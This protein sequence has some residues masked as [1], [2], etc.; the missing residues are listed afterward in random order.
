M[1]VFITGASGF[2]GS[3]V[4]GAFARAGH[5]VCGLVRT[6]AK[7]RSLAT[8]EI[9]PI[10][11]SMDDPRTFA[12]R[13]GACEVLVHCA[14][15]YTE[16]FME[17]D[18]KTVEVLLGGAARTHRPRLFIYTSGVWVYGDTGDGRADESSET[19]PP[20]LVTARAETERMV[21]G[22]SQAALRTLVIRPGCVYGES[23]SLTAIWFDT[24]RKNGATRVVGEG[25]NRW[26]MI[27][28]H[29]LADLYLRAVESSCGGEVFNATDRSRSTVL[30][31]ARA[32][33]RAAGAG[34]KVENVSVAE[35]AKSLGPFAECLALS[36]HVDSSKAVRLLG[37]QPRHGG[38][39]DGAARYFAAWK[40]STAE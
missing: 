38:F 12:D 33:S 22:A 3:A 1:K 28:V 36:Q 37:W 30:E 20:R 34:G 27:H 8:R 17:L 18:K 24:A 16:R 14:A 19:N 39:A 2:I 29:D 6:A 11:G 21:L 32:A 23:G 9:E 5:D 4:A 13:A 26:A 35:A 31:C 40:G 7:A 25:A 15:E 10:V